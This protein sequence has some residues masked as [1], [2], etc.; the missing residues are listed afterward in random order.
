M[1]THL[2]IKYGYQ[3]WL[4]AEERSLLEQT[5]LDIPS[6]TTK[7]ETLYADIVS[8]YMQDHE[9]LQL[10]ELEHHKNTN[11]LMHSLHVSYLCFLQAFRLGWDYVSAAIGGLLHDFVLFTKKD[12]R[13][14]RIQDIWCFHHPQEALKK[15][16]TKYELSDI[17]KDIIQKHMFPIAFSF[18][19]HRET[20]L[21]TYW[22]KYC[23]IRE[24]LYKPA[25]A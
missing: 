21:I 25:R 8:Q 9:W 14:K 6:G 7:E 13:V 15:A 10:M 3:K 4:S 18:P 17:S 11:R 1:S 23:A 5:F 22:D 2:C 12:Y 24:F 19:K 16:E 20:W